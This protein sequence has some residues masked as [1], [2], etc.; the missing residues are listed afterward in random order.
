MQSRQN[1]PFMK[2]KNNTFLS[3]SRHYNISPI[4]V[5][6]FDYLPLYRP[7]ADPGF[8]IRGGTLKQNCWGISCEKSLFYVKKSYFF[9]I[10][11]E[12][13][14]RSRGEPPWIRLWRRTC[15]FVIDVEMVMDPVDCLM[16]LTGST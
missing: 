8:Q 16:T 12:G 13:A 7:G 10:L 14:G 15:T 6:L 11:R 1:I 3:D 2:Y 4:L 9:P 5:K